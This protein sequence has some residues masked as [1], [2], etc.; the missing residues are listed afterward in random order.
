MFF[1]HLITYAQKGCII[2]EMPYFCTLLIFKILNICLNYNILL[3]P[4]LKNID[5]YVKLL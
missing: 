1:K 3:I 2:F 5:F 4:E